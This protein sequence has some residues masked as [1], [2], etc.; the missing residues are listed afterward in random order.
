MIG[1]YAIAA[2]ALIAAGAALGIVALV[3]LGIRR[4]E[5]TS[6]RQGAVSLLGRSPGRA[7]D[8][9]RIATGIYTHSPLTAYPPPPPG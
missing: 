3:T 8:C 6:R 1:I 2:A 7:A 9:A 5:K 4:E